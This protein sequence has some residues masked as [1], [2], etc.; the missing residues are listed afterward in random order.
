M[1]MGEPPHNRSEKHTDASLGVLTSAITDAGKSIV[2][3]GLI[4]GVLGLVFVVGFIGYIA[5]DSA[6]HALLQRE[7]DVVEWNDHA[8]DR[9]YMTDDLLEHRLHVGMSR[10][11]VDALFGEQTD[12]DLPRPIYEYRLGSIPMGEKVLRIQFNEGGVVA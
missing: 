5:F 12:G 11:E 4:V 3:F 9:I 6:K 2:L 7:F 8:E 10:A 1:S